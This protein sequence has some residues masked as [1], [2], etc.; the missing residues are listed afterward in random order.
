MLLDLA[1]ALR[2]TLERAI[3][4]GGSS[5]R[6]FVDGHGQ[7][8]YFQQTYFVYGRAGD[9]C[10]VCSRAIQILRQGNRATYYCPKCQKK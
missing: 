4:A 1:D 10:R 8:G 9:P 7:P 3:E 5:L 6:D 2:R